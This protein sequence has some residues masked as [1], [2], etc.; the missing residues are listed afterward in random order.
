MM[1]MCRGTAFAIGTDAPTKTF[2]SNRGAERISKETKN[3]PN[4]KPTFQINDHRTREPGRTFPITDFHY[5]SVALGNYSG[6]CAGA[7]RPSFHTLSR[8]YFNSEE[9]HYF[10]A[11]ATVFA[12]I[13]AT[14]ALPILNG[15]R[16]MMELIRAIGGT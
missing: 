5:H 15:A 12:V 3:Y 2:E 9:R 7:V 14:A 11:E 8:D 16:A 4:M 10:L 6:R 1:A 13:M